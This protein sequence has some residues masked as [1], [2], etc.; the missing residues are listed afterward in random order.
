MASLLAVVVVQAAACG[1][2]SLPASA[3]EPRAEA[4]AA[5]GG[6][7]WL[8]PRHSGLKLSATIEGAY[9]YGTC[10]TA[11][12]SGCSPP[13]QVQNR[14][15]C[16][17]NPLIL[18]VA[19]SRVIRLRGAIAAVYGSMIDVGAGRHTVTVF[20]PGRRKTLRAARSLR[21]HP[22]AALGGPLPAPRPLPIVLAELRRAVD[23]KARHGTVAAVAR[24]TGLKPWQVRAR[25]RY[26]TLLG[27][28][29]LAGVEPPSRPW[30][31]VARERQIA[32]NV[33]AFGSRRRAAEQAGIT[34]A[35]VRR[36]ERRVRGLSG[37]C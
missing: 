1:G 5:R 13:F 15:T 19:P 20:G 34:V 33:L 24:K 32:L 37:R 18:D 30:R 35:E 28:G 11:P 23:A 16:E 21:P 17:R 3:S 31:V 22:R 14:T 12:D 9:V 2:E 10:E 26:A 8:G 25:L 36:I 29:A 7:Y 27:P 6:P 4:A